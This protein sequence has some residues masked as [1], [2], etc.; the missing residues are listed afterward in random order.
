MLL[1]IFLYMPFCTYTHT[2]FL[3]TYPGVELLC[4]WVCLGDWTS[5]HS[6]LHFQAFQSSSCSTF[7][8]TLDIVCHFYFSYDCGCVVVSYC[9]INWAFL[10]TNEVV[11]LFICLLVIWISSFQHSWLLGDLLFWGR[12]IIYSRYDL[13]DISIANI[14]SHNVAC[15]NSLNSYLLINSL[16]F[17]VV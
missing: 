8:P 10:M 6:H 17:N 4:H 14:S 9:S 2:F 12:S 13:S 15:F 16:N 1:W 5:L 11:H 7:L 3:G